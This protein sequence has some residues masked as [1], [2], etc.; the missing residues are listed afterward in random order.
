[1]DRT[2]G[3]NRLDSHSETPHATL[4]RELTQLK[5]SYAKCEKSLEDAKSMIGQETNEIVVDISPEEEPEQIGDSTCFD[6]DVTER[7]LAA[8][9]NVQRAVNGLRSRAEY[10]AVNLAHDKHARQSSTK[11]EMEARRAVDG[12][13]NPDFFRGTCSLTYTRDDVWWYVDLEETYAIGEVKI[14]NNDRYPERID[15]FNV[16]VG[17]NSSEIDQMEQCG[18]DYG[19]DYEETPVFSIN[20]G[21]M[22][23]RYVAVS[24][25]GE[26]RSLNICE[27]RVYEYTGLDPADWD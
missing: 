12:N 27:V 21:G 4:K 25:P 11:Y 1:M 16:L 3:L 22:S 20:C 7:I 26:A 2:T 23:G 8:I 17:K 5:E 13:A 24:L 6:D 10:R 19:A 14:Y 15:P 18:G 9:S